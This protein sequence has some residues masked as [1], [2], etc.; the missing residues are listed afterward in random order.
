MVKQ[1]DTSYDLLNWIA[2]NL[3]IIDKFGHLIGLYPNIGQLILYNTMNLQ[4]ERNLPVRINLLKPRQV[5]WTT[6]CEAEGFTDV[7][8]KP[9]W[10]AMAVSMDTDSTDVVFRMTRLFHAEIPNPRPTDNTNRKELVFSAPHRSR[11]V[12]QTAG[13]VGVGRSD[14]IQYLHCSEVAFWQNAKEQLA[15]LYQV[16]PNM[17]G[18]VIIKETTANGVGGAFYDNFWDAV[19]RRKSNPDDYTGYLPV[20]FPWYKFPEYDL[21]PPKTFSLTGEDKQLAGEFGL[22]AGQLYWR[23]IKIQELN[24]DES[25]FKQEYPATAREAFQASGN[26]VFTTKMLEFQESRAAKNPR[27]CIFNHDEIENVARRFNCWQI[28]TLPRHDHEYSMGIDTMEGRLSDVDD[29]KSDLDCDAVTIFDRTLGQIAA[30]Y[31][32][33]GDQDELA[34]QCLW[35]AQKYSNAWVAPELPHSMLVLKAFKDAGYEHI[36]NRQVHDEMIET[37]DSENLGWRTTLITRKWLVDDFIAALRGDLIVMFQ[38]LIGEMRTFIKDKTGK[39][40]HMPSKHDDI[41]F[42]AMIALQ[43]HLRCPLEAKPYPYGS[44]LDS[45]DAEKPEPK[46]SIVYS[47]AIDDWQPYDEDDDF[48]HTE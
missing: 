24:G 14:R 2:R 35:A 41:L 13:K 12:S 46:R 16:V 9:N 37:D 1:T 30:I 7:Y 40:T 22:T 4:R 31:H 18:T 39:P 23:R 19:E 6:W 34:K 44:T 28:A 17:P 21:K 38:A 25:L 42:S 10:N 11:F 27:Y 43:V 26:A 20:F 36:Y 29:P 3:K 5:G 47:G 48:L 15:G 45:E 33:R 8:H 32:G